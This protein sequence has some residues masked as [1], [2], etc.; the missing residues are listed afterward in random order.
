MDL[1]MGLLN[2]ELLLWLVWLASLLWHPSVWCL[3]GL[4]VDHY[5]LPFFVWV[6]GFQTLIPQA[7]MVSPLVIELCP[8]PPEIVIFELKSKHVYMCIRKLWWKGCVDMNDTHTAGRQHIRTHIIFTYGTWHHT[9]LSLLILVH[10]TCIL[11]K[12][13]SILDIWLYMSLEEN[14]DRLNICQVL[15]MWY[16]YSWTVIYLLNQH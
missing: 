12:Y 4:Q 7:C 11:L 14:K 6:L 8:Q 2:P 9:C 13:T 1:G 16:H 10:W 3:L 5:T 15:I